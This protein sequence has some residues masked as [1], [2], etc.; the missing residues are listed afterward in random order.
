MATLKQGKKTLGL[1]EE[2]PDEQYQDLLASE[3]LSD[4]LN[5]PD[6]KLVDRKVFQN[7][8]AKMKLLEL[9]GTITISATTKKFVVRDRIQELGRNN[10]IRV[11][12]N[13]KDWFFNKTVEPI[14]GTDLYYY[15]L[16]K[17]AKNS[18][19]IK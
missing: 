14:P 10:H 5:C 15:K 2:I 9:I 13:F 7:V 12:G 3:L 19:I 6:P 17:R 16:K 11:E 4:L 18:Q 1:I 8:L